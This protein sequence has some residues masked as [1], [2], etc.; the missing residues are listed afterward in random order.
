[1]AHGRATPAAALAA[2][3]LVV[4]LVAVPFP[5]V[6]ALTATPAAI[7]ARRRGATCPSQQGVQFTKPDHY[8][9]LPAA[10]AGACCAA[11]QADA[12]KC[13][14]WKFQQTVGGADDSQQCRLLPGPPTAQQ[15]DSSFVSGMPGSR[16]QCSITDFG[17]VGDG[18]TL[19]TAAIANAIAACDH[20][21]VPGSTHDGGSGDDAHFLTGTVLLRSNMRLTISAGA[22]LQG[23]DGQFL[24]PRPNKWDQYQDYGHSHWYDSF[25]VGDGVTNVTID[26]TGMLDGGGLSTGQPKHSGGGCRLI[27]L[28]EGAEITLQDFSTRNG[29]W[30][31]LLATGVSGLTIT[32]VQVQAARDGLDIVGCTNVLVANVRVEGGGDDAVVLK[33]D[34]SLGRVIPVLNVTVRDS[35]IGSDGC[36][37]LNF[38]SETVGE[39]ANVTWENIQVTSAGKAGIGIASMD[40]A[41]VHDVT[42][43]NISMSGTVTPIFMYIG[44]RSRHPPPMNVGAITNISLVDVTAVECK[45][46][47][48]TWAATLDGQD[49]NATANVSQTFPVGP[50]IT[51]NNVD[52]SQCFQG[53]GTSADDSREPPHSPTAY[54]PRG[55]GVRPSYGLYVRNSVGV[56]FDSLSLGGK[57]DGRPAVVV[58]ESADI[59]LS[60]LTA[61]RSASAGSTYDVGLRH[62]ATGTQVVDSPGIVVR[63]V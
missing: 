26:G 11:C 52:L 53:T 24:P 19:N 15:P 39:F 51:L 14:A 12:A 28:R 46:Q 20:V 36:N 27:A 22:T 42:Y 61:Q 63:D 55:L 44:A 56:T 50:G 38:G 6:G 33:S 9:Q 37:A 1:M 57:A 13:G 41:H 8:K 4:L 17:A 54:V 31:T 62:G 43:R 23:Q 18:S 48:G 2:A 29:G 3:V 10:T 32:G 30:F 60:R 49:V 45:G 34:F 21:V 35:T 16:P 47:R 7:A 5:S 59:T 25:I 40:G 58:E